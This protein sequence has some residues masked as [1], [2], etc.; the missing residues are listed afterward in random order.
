LIVR[1]IRHATL[2][3]EIAG[4]VLL[5]DPM[6]D[7][8]GARPPIAN[9]EN[10]RRNPLVPLT[11]SLA[12]VVDGVDALLVTHLHE[13]HLDKGA[14][15]ALSPSLPLFCQPEDVGELR[16][17]GFTDVRPV[18]EPA[19]TG[20][21]ARGSG[22]GS[23][24]FGGIVITRTPARHG[25]GEIGERF[26]PASGF[27]VAAEGEPKVYVAGD[28]IWCGE[29]AEVLSREQPNV[30]V[31]NAGAA[32]F[33]EGGPITMDAADVADAAQGAPWTDIVAVHME[34]INHCLL[35]REGLRAKLAGLGLAAHVAIPA[36]GDTLTFD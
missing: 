32:Q 28:T 21:G 36:D 24:G 12:E 34:A 10:D 2:R 8:V 3:V 27:L 29:V 16:S 7:E 26:A 4:R 14:V 18:G 25:R 22:Y 35:T 6:L 31:V 17:R 20:P 9:T 30:T 1:L 13:D 19:T 23:V 11:M 15:A 5:V 33:V